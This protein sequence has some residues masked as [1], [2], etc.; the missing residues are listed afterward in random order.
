MLKK[1]LNAGLNLLHPK[2]ALLQ[3]SPRELPAL[4]PKPRRDREGVQVLR[5]LQ[6]QIH[7]LHAKIAAMEGVIQVAA[8]AAAEARAVL[9]AVAAVENGL[10]VA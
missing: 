4:S 10:D 7:S 9:V 6:F 2:L 1:L 5:L 3:R 8:T